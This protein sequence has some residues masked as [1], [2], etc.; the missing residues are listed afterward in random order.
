M[1]MAYKSIGTFDMGVLRE[2][3]DDPTTLFP[4]VS[5]NAKD[6]RI[7]EVGLDHDSVEL[8]HEDY[9]AS[10]GAWVEAGQFDNLANASDAT[11]AFPEDEAIAVYDY[12]DAQAKLM[13][14]ED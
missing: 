10:D 11:R 12:T 8:W 1:R 9:A 6:I 3:Y 2:F 4:S 7:M 5:E 14:R 13:L